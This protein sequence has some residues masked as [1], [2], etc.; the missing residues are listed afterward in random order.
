[1]S[2]TKE[3]KAAIARANGAKS[4]GPKT[5]EGKAVS[6]RN[7]L[8]HGISTKH[9]RH[10][11]LKEVEKES[12]YKKF[13]SMMCAS[14]KP[15]DTFQAV[16]VNRI[17]SLYWRLARVSRE[18]ALIVWEEGERRCSGEAPHYLIQNEGRMDKLL[19]YEEHVTKQINASL[20]ELEKLQKAPS[21]SSDSVNIST[22]P[23]MIREPDSFDD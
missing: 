20:R 22:L 5:R 10:F 18:E 8:K 16:L 4:R 3:Q 23:M 14:L 21:P 2:L 19:K 6:S 11:I 13:S 17:I 12:D 7:A 1:M 9:A 15:T